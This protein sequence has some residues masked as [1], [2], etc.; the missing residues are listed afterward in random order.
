MD[1]KI[2]FVIRNLSK[3]LNYIFIADLFEKSIE[4]AP[5]EFNHFTGIFKKA[6]VKSLDG[7]KCEPFIPF[8]AVFG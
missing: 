2:F 1:M 6:I 5:A 7:K 8:L 4:P 3:I